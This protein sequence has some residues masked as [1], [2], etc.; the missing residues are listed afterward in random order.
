MEGILDQHVC[1][2]KSQIAEPQLRIDILSKHSFALLFVYYDVF[3]LRSTLNEAVSIMIA[4]MRLNSTLLTNKST[5]LPKV[6]SDSDDGFQSVGVI[7][8]LFPTDNSYRGVKKMF[9]SDLVLSHSNV[10]SHV[11]CKSRKSYSI[12]ADL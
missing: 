4:V 2:N 5:S 1:D 3:Y 11:F 12:S 9:S 6:E 7:R 10:A 8:S